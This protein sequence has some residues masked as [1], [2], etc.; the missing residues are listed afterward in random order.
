LG[1]VSQQ[2]LCETLT[3]A[4]VTERRT[5]TVTNPDQSLG[6]GSGGSV[7]GLVSAVSFSADFSPGLLM[8]S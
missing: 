2:T 3:D 6:W 7:S 5:L 8:L 1:E 4:T